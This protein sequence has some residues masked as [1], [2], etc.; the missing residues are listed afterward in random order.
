MVNRIGILLVV[1]LVMVGSIG[2]LYNETYSIPQL[3]PADYDCENHPGFIS[4][5]NPAPFETQ[6]DYVN[7]KN[8]AVQKQIE[9]VCD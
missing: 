7:R 3:I 4:D 1:C 8:R 6:Q 9:E 2:I 5:S